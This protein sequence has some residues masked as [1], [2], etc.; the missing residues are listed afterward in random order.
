M[1]KQSF[2]EKV[3][4][5]GKQILFYLIIIISLV[6]G[7]SLG[8]HYEKLKSMGHSSKFTPTIIKKSDVNLAIDEKNNILI[9]NKNDGT[10]I[11]YQDSIGYTI[12]NFYA[13]NIWSEHSKK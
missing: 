8:Y 11:M 4:Q 2:I 10:Y 1:D 3:K 6:V 13:K 12:F 7:I 9:V 5:I